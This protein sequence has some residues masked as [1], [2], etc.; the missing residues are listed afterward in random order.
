MLA[1]RVFAMYFLIKCHAQYL[2]MKLFLLQQFLHCTVWHW[3][4]AYHGIQEKAEYLHS[5]IALFCILVLILHCYMKTGAAA[6]A[7]CPKIIRF[8]SPHGL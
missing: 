6:K 3:T 7:I 1:A 4:V 8:H 2:F 5:F